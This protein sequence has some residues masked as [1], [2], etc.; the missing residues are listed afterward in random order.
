MRDLGTFSGRCVHDGGGRDQKIGDVVGLRKGP[1]GARAFLWNES[2]GMQELGALAEYTNTQALAINDSG[3]VVGTLSNSRESR[4]FIWTAEAGMRDLNS[5]LSP[6]AGV[7]LVSASVI[8]NSGQIVASATDLEI[9][10]PEGE[11]AACPL[12]ECAPAPKYS[13]LLTPATGP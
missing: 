4:A 2:K 7:V 12:D 8:N 13:F 3:T 1:E 11:T 9:P 5:A 10:C 6:E